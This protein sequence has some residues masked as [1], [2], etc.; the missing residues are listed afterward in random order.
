M[1]ALTMWRHFHIFLYFLFTLDI[2]LRD[3]KLAGLV[4]TGN[5]K[6]TLQTLANSLSDDFHFFP[7][8]ISYVVNMFQ[9]S[10]PTVRESIASMYK[11]HSS[12]ASCGRCARHF[13]SRTENLL[14]N[15]KRRSPFQG[16]V[17]SLDYSTPNMRMEMCGVHS[18]HGKQFCFHTWWWC[19]PSVEPPKY[20]SCNPPKS[21]R[22]VSKAFQGSRE[23]W[24]YFKEWDSN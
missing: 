3:P 13:F 16:Q 12:S 9:R 15:S 20:T 1:V 6:K 19:A 2:F 23:L 18:L 5:R 21:S 14:W 24:Q 10:Y 17:L 11:D 4:S 22:L 7:K 8:I